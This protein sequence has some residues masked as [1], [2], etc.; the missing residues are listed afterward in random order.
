M[1]YLK[2]FPRQNVTCN[3]GSN[4][5]LD[6]ACT[7]SIYAL[8]GTNECECHDDPD[9]MCHVCCNNSLR[10]GSSCKLHTG[11]CDSFGFCIT[12]DS[13]DLMNSL[14]DAFKRLFSKAAMNSLW[15]WIKGH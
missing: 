6:G 9:E 7:G 10:P 3:S 1:V 12:V 13:D 15:D 8:Y 14:R 11:C 4:T 5:C 2:Q